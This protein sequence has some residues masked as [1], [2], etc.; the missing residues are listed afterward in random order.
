MKRDLAIAE[1]ANRTTDLKARGAVAA[2]LFGS[3]MRDEA[4]DKS[5]LDLFIDVMP[6][7]KFSLVDL[8]GIQRFLQDELRTAVDVTTRGS[9]HPKLRAEIEREALRIY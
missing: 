2:F 3:T 9:L 1:I 7:R 8:A 4:D 5:D 6:D